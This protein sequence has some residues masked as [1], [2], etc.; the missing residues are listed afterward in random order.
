MAYIKYKELTKYFNFNAEIDTKE[1]PS[2]VTDY[3]KSGEKPIQAYKTSRDKGL[4]TNE[5]MILFDVNPLDGSKKIHIIPYSS[6]SSGAILFKR[7]SGAILLSFD[8]G[9]QLKLNFV[10]LD[11]KGKTELRKL[12][13]YM[14]NNR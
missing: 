12:F 6:I 2:Y 13:S 14:L 7:T 3:M 11:A 5:R 4:F 10:K 1:L 8:S 9:Y